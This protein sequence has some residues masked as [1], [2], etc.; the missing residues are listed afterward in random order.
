MSDLLEQRSTSPAKAGSSRSNIVTLTATGSSSPRRQPP[1]A[2]APPFEARAASGSGQAG[3]LP[4]GDE[5]AQ[6]A[7]GRAR[8]CSHC[9]SASTPHTSPLRRSNFGSA[10]RSRRA[11]ARHA[12][13][14]SARAGRGRS[15]EALVERATPSLLSPCGVHRHV[16]PVQERVGIG[17]IVGEAPRRPRPRPALPARRRSSGAPTIA[18]RRAR[19]RAP[20]RSSADGQDGSSSP[21]SP[22]A[23]SRSGPSRM[24]SAPTCAVTARRR[25]RGR[26]CR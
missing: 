15:L 17:A 26:T 10:G 6:A 24:R 3:L 14:S 8:G 9:T 20:R 11:R 22:L 5:L 19:G 18:A 12:A 23:T 2:R 1:P 21:S 4:R 16:R 25:S 7:P 13:R